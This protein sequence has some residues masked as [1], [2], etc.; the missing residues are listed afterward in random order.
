[1]RRGVLQGKFAR[2]AFEQGLDMAEVAQML[3]RKAFVLGSTDDIG[4]YV[5]RLGGKFHPKAAA[6]TIAAVPPPPVAS[7]SPPAT[8]VD[9]PPALLPAARSSDAGALCAANSVAATMSR[10]RT[11]TCDTAAAATCAA[12][13]S[14]GAGGGAYSRRVSAAALPDAASACGGGQEG[15]ARDNAA[16]PTDPSQ[17]APHVA[18][19]DAAC[20][21]EGYGRLGRAVRWGLLAAAAV[22]GVALFAARRRK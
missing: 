3:A 16:G 2:E 22:V 1:M 14:G 15:L 5:L 4:V 7:P 8:A 12:R 19:G 18:T 20:E 11:A 21:P 9:T 13:V 10:R 17:P 6:G